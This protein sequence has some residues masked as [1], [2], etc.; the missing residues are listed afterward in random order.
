MQQLRGEQQHMEQQEEQG[1][2]YAS[3]MGPLAP[4]PSRPLMH[5]PWQQRH[6]SAVGLSS[7]D[8]AGPA[9]PQ[10]ETATL[11]VDDQSLEGSD[12]RR[13]APSFDGAK[14]GGVGGLGSPWDLPQA[15]RVSDSWGPLLEP[16]PVVPE[17]WNSRSI[18]T[19][20]RSGLGLLQ[21]GTGR[22]ASNATA[23]GAAAR[24]SASNWGKS[25]SSGAPSSAST[26]VRTSV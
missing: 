20:F 1:A 15:V 19:S 11:G 24:G 21:V 26:S 16:S 12:D 2:A 10:R 6:G 8:I 4:R 9:G 14:E 7:Y 5:G 17:R 22:D 25:V 3:S 13:T 18:G 23:A